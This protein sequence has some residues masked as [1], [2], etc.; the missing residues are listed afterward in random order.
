[1]VPE[2]SSVGYSGS[3]ENIVQSP[4]PVAAAQR[5]QG[6]ADGRAGAG[7]GGL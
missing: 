1:M 3:A 4:T 2:C 6:A 5:A 7:E